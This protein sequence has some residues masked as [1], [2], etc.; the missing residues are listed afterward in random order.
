MLGGKWTTVSHDQIVPG[1]Y[2]VVIDDIPTFK[3]KAF[4]ACLAVSNRIREVGM[5]GY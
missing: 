4:A 2:R 1:M 5:A 3:Y